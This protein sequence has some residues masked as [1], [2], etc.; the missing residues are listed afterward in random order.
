LKTCEVPLNSVILSS[1]KVMTYLTH[2]VRVG[3][4]AKK[5]EK[6][7]SEQGLPSLESF[8]ASGI[9]QYPVA[10]PEEIILEFLHDQTLF[11]LRSDSVALK[12]YL[13]KPLYQ[14]PQLNK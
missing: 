10:L 1:S 8:F 2:G 7:L 4:V 5:Y 9:E 14:E 12:A 3:I 6:Y 11:L 13:A